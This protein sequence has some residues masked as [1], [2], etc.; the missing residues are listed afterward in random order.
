MKDKAIFLISLILVVVGVGY[1]GYT[2]YRFFTRDTNVS[3]T[4]QEAIVDDT[5]NTGTLSLSGNSN[6]ELI[7]ANARQGD[8]ITIEADLQNNTSSR[9]S[10]NFEGR[11]YKVEDLYTF[12]DVE[13]QIPVNVATIPVTIN[14]NS[15]SVFKFDHTVAECGN[16]YIA[17]ATDEYWN[18]GR[19]IVS[20]GYYTVNCDNSFVSDTSAIGNV[21]DTNTTKG[22]LQVTTTPSPSITPESVDQLPKAGPAEDAMLIGFI[23][24]LLGVWYRVKYIH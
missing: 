12:P 17:L 18:T 10:S 15:N 9:V 8:T 22:G 21:T 19:G 13:T 4:D 7:N 14:E 24:L 1:L 16:Y 6:K 2:A 23:A 5:T 3:V 20:Y 11:V